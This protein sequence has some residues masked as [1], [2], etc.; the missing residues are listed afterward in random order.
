[1]LVRSGEILARFP[2][3]QIDPDFHRAEVRFEGLRPPISSFEA[4]LFLDEDAPT[5]AT[6][7]EGNPHYLGSEWFYGLGAEQPLQS[8]RQPVVLNV[9]AGLRR[10]L[11]ASGRRDGALRIVTVD[12]DGREIAAPELDVEGISLVT[13]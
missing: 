4:R 9:T 10:Y 11:G 8:E 3:D 13:T 5:A 7:T 6:P 12:D 1:M 2:L